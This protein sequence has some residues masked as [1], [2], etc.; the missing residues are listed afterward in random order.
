MKCQ[1]AE[2]FVSALCDG[3]LIPRDAAQHLDT[4]E[5]CQA[6]LREYFEMGA[7]LRLMGSLEMQKGVPGR[8]WAKKQSGFTNLWEKVWGT[9]MI[10][11]FAFGLLLAAVVVLGS[12][13][14]ATRAR[15]HSEGPVVMFSITPKGGQGNL[16]PMPTVGKLD[17]A[18]GF[19]SSS[20]SYNIRVIARDGDRIKLGAQSSYRESSG[21]NDHGMSWEQFRKLPE[22][23]YFFTP[24]DRLEI[25]VS[26]T[27]PIEVTGEWMDHM[28]PMPVTPNMDPKAGEL[29]IFSP[30]LLKA[31]N[32]VID[33]EG[34][35]ATGVDTGRDGVVLYGQGEGRF[36]FGLSPFKGAIEA[37]ISQNRMTFK[38]DG[39]PYTLITGAPISRSEVAW[40]R[41][42]ARS[43]P[44]GE[45]QAATLFIGTFKLS[46]NAERK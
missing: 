13:L 4:C 25:P 28:P 30:V 39:Q 21:Q 45:E 9:M 5:Y 17:G 41:R 36:E 22:E 8:A 26:G 2:E 19:L 34:G 44:E 14:V 1:E 42:D 7:E 24:G 12:S 33:M 31:K 11:R 37:K 38:I 15:A 27:G 16:C 46:E 18:C 6:R 40:V 32:V 3:E 43:V 23:T 29:R 20:L 35:S 10:P